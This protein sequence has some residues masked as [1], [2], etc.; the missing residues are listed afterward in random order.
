MR[1]VPLLNDGDTLFTPTP[2]TH[3]LGTANPL[4]PDDALTAGRGRG[5]SRD[6]TR[7]GHRPVGH[8]VIDGAETATVLNAAQAANVDAT[9][10]TVPSQ[11][12][13]LPRKD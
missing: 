5:D 10:I 7:C 12:E 3:P 1:P 13:G 8:A 4:A 2:G 6:R 11:L 9:P